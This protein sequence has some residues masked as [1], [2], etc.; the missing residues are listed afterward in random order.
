M[1]R[2]LQGNLNMRLDSIQTPTSSDCATRVAWAGECIADLCDG[3]LPIEA[4]A[5]VWNYIVGWMDLC[6]EEERGWYGALAS[7]VQGFVS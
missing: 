6:T 4:A 2:P 1:A 5:I 3:T 7:R